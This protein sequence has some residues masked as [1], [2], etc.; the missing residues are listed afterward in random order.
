[1]AGILLNLGLSS[2]KIVIG[3]MIGSHAMVLDALNGFSDMVS[4]LVSLFS[5]L[6]AS[7]HSDRKHPFG[8]G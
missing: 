3:L 5:V 2:V 8:Y 4:S 6:L 1:M 7:R